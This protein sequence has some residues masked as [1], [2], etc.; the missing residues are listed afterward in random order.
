MVTG[1]LNSG[2]KATAMYKRTIQN[3]LQLQMIGSMDLS[4]PEKPAKF[5]MSLGFG[6]M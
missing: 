3:M 1:V 2:M 6:A 5:G 4:K